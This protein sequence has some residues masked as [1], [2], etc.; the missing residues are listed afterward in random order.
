MKADLFQLALEKYPEVYSH[1][2]SRRYRRIRLNELNQ[3]ILNPNYS[4]YGLGNS[5]DY[6][7]AQKEP[8]I[9]EF[10]GEPIIVEQLPAKAGNRYDYFV[11]CNLKRSSDGCDIKHWFNFSSLFLTDSSS[12]P[13]YPNW[14]AL[15]SPL[16]VIENLFLLR[17]L[18]IVYKKEHSF[19]ARFVTNSSPWIFPILPDPIKKSAEP[20]GYLAQYL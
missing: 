10:T 16:L 8:I 15:H 17:K 11:S 4:G 1:R 14:A 13:L 12:R 3:I 19:A 7:N 9:Y 6:F 20:D 2:N 18:C 5:L